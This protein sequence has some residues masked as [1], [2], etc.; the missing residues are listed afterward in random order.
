MRRF[1]PGPG[2]ALDVGCAA[3]FF[4]KVLADEGWSVAGVES[5]PA[6]AGHASEVYGLPPV[7][8]GDLASAPFPPGSFDL[9]TMWDLVE[10]VPDPVALLERAAELLAPEG[11]LVIETQNVE[12]PFSRLMGPRWQ[13]YKHLEHLYHFGPATL[14]ALL[15]RTGFE[16]LHRTARF[17]GKNV[18]LGFI[19]ERATRVHPWLGTLLAPLRPVDRLHLYVNLFD[20]MIVVAKRRGA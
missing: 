10:H 2:R 8:V 18:S 5:S 6:I 20:E 3:G 16:R 17:G 1:V 15:A 19:R 12:S 4:L 7:H 11:R 13:H 14:D 9:V